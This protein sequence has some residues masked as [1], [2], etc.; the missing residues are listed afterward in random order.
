MTVLWWAVVIEGET[1]PEALGPD[2]TEAKA[3]G[4]ADEWNATRRDEGEAHVRPLKRS[5]T[6]VDD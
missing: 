5:L 1:Y 2:R 6:D 3:Q 4:L